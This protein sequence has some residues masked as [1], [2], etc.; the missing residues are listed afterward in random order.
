[1]YRYSALVFLFM[2]I[3]F[4]GG[5]A[6]S[7]DNENTKTVTKAEQTTETPIMDRTIQY[8]E[9]FIAVDYS[10]EKYEEPPIM[11]INRYN[12][13]SAILSMSM[14]EQEGIYGTCPYG[15]WGMVTLYTGSE[16]MRS[17]YARAEV[18][19]MD[20]RATILFTYPMGDCETISY[21]KEWK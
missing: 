4:C 13:G 14:G 5:C 7:T 11:I 6:N 1:M 12:D 3:F 10:N 16:S 8:A 18:T 19:I 2:M 9:K 21:E 15:V 20:N 17:T